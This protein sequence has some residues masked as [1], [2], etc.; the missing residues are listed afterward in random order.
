MHNFYKRW[1]QKCKKDTDDFTVFFA[2]LE[3]L[4]LKLWVNMLVKLTPA[5]LFLF[6]HLTCSNLQKVSPSDFIK[7]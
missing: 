3:Y 1:S 7:M 4:Q 2:L 6:F 5:G